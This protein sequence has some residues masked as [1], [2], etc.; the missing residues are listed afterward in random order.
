MVLDVLLIISDQ[1]KSSKLKNSIS[2]IHKYSI[3]GSFFILETKIIIPFLV[4]IFILLPIN[5]KFINLA[6]E[7][8][9]KDYILNSQ[10]RMILQ[11]AIN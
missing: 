7:R 2:K 4:R 5:N 3:S 1:P 9:S 8:I 10:R 6:I 11:F